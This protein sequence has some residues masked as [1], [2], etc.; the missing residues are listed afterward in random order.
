MHMQH[1]NQYLVP[2]STFDTET[3]LGIINQQILGITLPICLSIPSP[4]MA[5]NVLQY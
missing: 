2:F 1:I 4:G 5:E 3:E